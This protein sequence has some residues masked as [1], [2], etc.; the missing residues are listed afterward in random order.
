MNLL[1]DK[2]VSITSPVAGTTRDLVSTQVMIGGQQLILTDT[3]GIRLSDDL[4]ER[5]GIELA[6]REILKANVLIFVLDVSKL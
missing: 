3:A 2:R 1:A 4:V 6:K 5:E